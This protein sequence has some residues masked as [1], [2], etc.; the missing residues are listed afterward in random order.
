M[1]FNVSKNY[2]ISAPQKLYEPVG[3]DS[4]SRGLVL[5]IVA[6]LALFQGITVL[7]LGSKGAVLTIGVAYMFFLFRWP[8]LV[9]IAGVVIIFDGLGFIDP[10]AFLR[11]PGLFKLK[12]LVFLSFFLPLLFNE[13]WH[14]RVR[15]V[16]RYARNLIIPILIILFLATLQMLRTSLQYDLPLNT[17]IMAGRHYWYY[18]FV[19]LTAVYLDTSV[20]RTLVFRLFLVVISALASVVILQ[21]IV[22][23]QGGQLFL[24]DTIQVQPGQWGI[25]NFF[26]IYIPGE[27]TL[28][29][30][31]SMAFWGVFLCKSAREKF[32]YAA[33]ALLCALAILLVNSRMRWVHAILTVMIPAFFLGPHILKA[34]RRLICVSALLAFILLPMFVLSGLGEDLVSGIGSRAFSAWTD[35]RGKTGTWEYRI[36]DSRFRIG[37]IKKHPLFGVGFVHIDY[38]GLF[39]ATG[40]PEDEQ[41][42]PSQGISTTDS[43]IIALLV[44][45]GAIGVL[46]AMW[47]FITVLGFCSKMLRSP[48]SGSL[49]WISIPLIGYMTGGVI[50]FITLC[51]FT[52]SGDIV[53]H[54]FALGVLASGTGLQLKNEN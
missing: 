14:K 34:G 42:F 30:G 31:F 19:L 40:L 7:W 2:R 16:F 17:C 51:L 46:W 21:T 39:G 37:L 38:A 29:L 32:G 25:L 35:F 27:P 47:Y 23:E 50:T 43:G 13:R 44:D 54:S 28:V 8:H 9:L 48:K 49:G 26:R 15:F 53:G 10:D 6:G 41:T 45:F 36:E 52:M 3:R 22:I 1:I 12:D 4:I 5:S 20:K 24:A 18:A 33:L 11:A